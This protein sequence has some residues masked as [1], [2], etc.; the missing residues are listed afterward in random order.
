MLVLWATLSIMFLFGTVVPVTHTVRLRN[1]SNE[2]GIFIEFTGS[3][4]RCHLDQTFELITTDGCGEPTPPGRT[5]RIIVAKNSTECA[6]F[7]TVRCNYMTMSARPLCWDPEFKSF[8]NC[9]SGFAES[10]IRRE[11]RDM[12][13]SPLVHQQQSVP[14]RFPTSIIKPIAVLMEWGRFLIP[15]G[16]IIHGVLDSA[17]KHIYPFACALDLMLLLYSIISLVAFGTG[18]KID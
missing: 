16:Y 4:P 1:G 11:R 3:Y 13:A 14:P 17:F 12:Q 2:T 9:P 8:D 5:M 6:I 7:P 15:G 10:G 18:Q